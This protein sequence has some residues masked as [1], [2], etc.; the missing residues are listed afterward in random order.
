ME[1]YS[2]N[3]NSPGKLI[4]LPDGNWAFKP[5]PLPPRLAYSPQLLDAVAAASTSLGELRGISDSL[6][7]ASLLLRPFLRMEAV[8]SSRIEGTRASLED[9]L[10]SEG[11]QLA[12]FEE[13]GDVREVQNYVQ[14]LEFG[15]GRMQ[16]LPVSLRL[17]RELHTKLMT[18]VRGN[19]SRAGEFRTRQN[20]I[21]PRGASLADATF[22]PPPP[23]EMLAGLSTL[24]RF[25][26]DEKKI[27]DLIRIGL[28]HYQ[29][30]A[31][32]PFADGNGRI[33]RLL[34][35]L[36]LNQWG[37]MPKPA[38]N[39]SA[40]LE[41]ER[42]T[43]YTRLLGVS[44]R[45]EWEEWLRFFLDG[46]SQESRRSIKRIRALQLLRQETLSVTGRERNS[47]RLGLVLREFF[48]SPILSVRQAASRLGIAYLSAERSIQR[49]VELGLVREITGRARNR[50]FQADGIMRIL[51]E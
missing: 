5:N 13:S 44:Q 15:L 34:I 17:I 29:F 48:S 49:L 14:A 24:E 32:H 18:G 42:Q 16:D 7:D 6:E 19:E 35:S 9:V 27:Q 26:H 30:E 36:L 21:G 47:D 1:I 46:M 11:R 22:V 12:L 31:L 41:A 43:Y 45:G 50:I 38:F 28:I 51:K 25:I 33:G 8:L 37:W 40:A 2:F 4:K 20:W 39:P 23:K 10:M 3:K